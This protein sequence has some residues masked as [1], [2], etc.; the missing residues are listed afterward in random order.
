MSTSVRVVAGLGLGVLALLAG[1]S[2]RAVAPPDPVAADAPVT[3]FSAERAHEHIVAIADEPRPIGTSAHAEAREYLVGQLRDLGLE[4]RIHTATGTT[5]GGSAS[6]VAMGHVQN[7]VTVIEGSDSTGQVVLAAHYDSVPSGPGANDDGAGIA[8]ILETARA[9][10]AERGQLRNDVVLLLTDGEEQGLLGAEAFVDD[11]PLADAGGVLLNHEA[12]GGSGA[13][14]MFRAS[15]GRADLIRTFAG[16]ASHPVA[17]STTATLFELIPSDTDFTAFTAGQFEGMDFAY[18]AD[19]AVYHSALDTPENV[20]PRSLQHMGANTLAMTRALGGQDLAGPIDEPDLAY[21][22]IP[23]G[24]LVY[25]GAGAMVPLAVLALALWVGASL[26]LRARG[27][28][29]APRVL[30]GAAAALGLVAVG[31][32]AA[33]AYWQV[34]LGLRPGL[35]LLASG[36]AYRPGLLQAGFLLLALLIGALWYALCRRL[37][38]PVGTWSGGLGALTGAGVLL[39]ALAPGAA[40][41]VV[42]PALGASAGALAAAL[43]GVERH[44]GRVAC[45]AAGLVPAAILLPVAVWG[46]FEGGL[47]LSPY[48]SV[49]LALI[50]ALLLTPLAEVWRAGRAL[51]PAAA[52]V[53]L[54]GTT[55]G[56]MA[57]NPLDQTQPTPTMLTY[58][59]DAD[60]GE[61]VWAA[62]LHPVFSTG[63]P[64]EWAA[65][66][67]GTD[68]VADPTPGQSWPQPQAYVGAAEATQLPGPG[69]EVLEETTTDDGRRS[70]H[71]ELTT[72][73]GA[74]SLGMFLPA[75]PSDD[76]EILVE[77][78]EVQVTPDD[79]GRIG[80]RYFGL[81][82][83]RGL[84]VEIRTAAEQVEAQ[85]VDFDSLASDLEELPGFEAPPPEHYLLLS[86]LSVVR[87]YDV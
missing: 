13:A 79:A 15:P 59:L 50:T 65:T 66:Y 2:L 71:L 82:A 19:G 55:I 28:T 74:E 38:G 39:A 34:L 84:E 72:P 58:S 62:P 26:V 47:E 18:L 20:D 69:L 42:L 8:A 67:V 64:D 41:L 27:Q 49:P 32:G 76:T 81:P 29:T 46:N 3:A 68:V 37:I 14:I 16:S 75:G 25:F 77:G 60:T 70:V 80:F 7:I 36:S 33:L 51:L 10:Q 52:V 12:R 57:A 56:G 4:P 44:S 78:R 22:N 48:T 83:G 30:A 9:L 87:T 54:V 24:N 35:A 86:R 40:T 23:G 1:L 85:V 73:R 31:V 5:P 53:A 17:D 43:L 45:L 6:P 63:E 61:A 11:H 21:F